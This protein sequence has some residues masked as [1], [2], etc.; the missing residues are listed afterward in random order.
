[1]E[2]VEKFKNPTPAPQAPEGARDFPVELMGIEPTASRVRCEN[3]GRIAN[4]F[5]NLERQETPE[6]VRKRLILA[7][8]SQD[9]AGSI[10]KTAR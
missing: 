7:A 2:T 10:G 4:H 3:D 1:M 8:C 9:A 5:S 6:N